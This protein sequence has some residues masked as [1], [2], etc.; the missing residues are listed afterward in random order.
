MCLCEELAGVAQRAESVMEKELCRGRLRKSRRVRAVVDRAAQA[1]W[2]SEDR[3]GKGVPSGRG[4]MPV[5]WGPV[6]WVLGERGM[7]RD[8]VA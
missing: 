8:G 6:E 1:S 5:L 3:A 7:R 4:R 2:E